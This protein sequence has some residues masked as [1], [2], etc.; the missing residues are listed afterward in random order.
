MKLLL[1]VAA[2]GSVC[3]L[4]GPG[5]ADGAKIQHSDELDPSDVRTMLAMLGLEAHSFTLSVD[6]GEFRLNVV[7]EEYVKGERVNTYDL[8]GNIDQG[9]LKALGGDLAVSK[10]PSVLKLFAL[11]QDGARVT[12]RVQKGRISHILVREVDKSSDS[13]G[14]DFKFHVADWIT[15][16]EDPSLKPGARTPIAAYTQPYWDKGMEAYRY[17]F[18]DPDM[19]TWGKRFGVPTYFV[20]SVELLEP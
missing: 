1:G 2:L 16:G 15:D 17:C 10:E 18:F 13:S 20:V 3:L 11:E 14:A 5:S 6:E 9:T 7:I 12:L 19:A 8:W 4:L